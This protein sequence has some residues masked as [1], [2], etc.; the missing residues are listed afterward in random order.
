MAMPTRAR[1]TMTLTDTPAASPD[2]LPPEVIM[3]AV[4]SSVEVTL[5]VVD[6]ST[7]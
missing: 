6:G 4:G 2:P 5:I 3:L 7:K 1:I